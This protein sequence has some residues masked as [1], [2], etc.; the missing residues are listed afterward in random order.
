MYDKINSDIYVCILSEASKYS[1]IDFT[2]S[3]F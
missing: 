3:N 1:A 2:D